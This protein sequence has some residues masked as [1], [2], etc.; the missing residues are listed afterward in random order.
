MRL[1]AS[2]KEL[3]VQV[4]ELGGR[5]NRRAGGEITGGVQA[6]SV[7]IHKQQQSQCAKIWRK[8][9]TRAKRESEREQLIPV[10]ASQYQAAAAAHHDATRITGEGESR[11]QIVC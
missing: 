11:S 10:W 8:G 4:H 1:P 5:R 2:S 6:V 3:A 7:D 9:Q